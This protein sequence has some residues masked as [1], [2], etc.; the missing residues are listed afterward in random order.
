MFPGTLC[1]QDLP[2]LKIEFAPTLRAS[3]NLIAQSVQQVAA[4]E[5]DRYPLVHELGT[6]LPGGPPTMQPSKYEEKGA[7]DGNESQ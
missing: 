5:A 1:G 7:K 4:F 6:K 3:A 2:H